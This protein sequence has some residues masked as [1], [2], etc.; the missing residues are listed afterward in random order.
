MR[1]LHQINKKIGK[2]FSESAGEYDII[3]IDS[4]RKI[5]YNIEVKNLKL[6]STTYEM[7]RQ[8]YGFYHKNKYELKF[9]NRIDVLNEH[10]KTILQCCFINDVD[11]Y[12][13]INIFLLYKY[14]TPLYATRKEIL[15]LSFSMLDDYFNFQTIYHEVLNNNK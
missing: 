5:I 2:N 7:Y 3:A 15:Y 12:I 4:K 1:N 10:Y 11:K 9:A 6:F 8:Y 14:F 13:I